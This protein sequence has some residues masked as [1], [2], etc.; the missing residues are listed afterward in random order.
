MVNHPQNHFLRWSKRA[1]FLRIWQKNGAKIDKVA[2][3]ITF[4]KKCIEI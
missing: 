4:V 2:K 3:N 1:D